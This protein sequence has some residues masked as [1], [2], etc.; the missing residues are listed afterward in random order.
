MRKLIYPAALA[1]DMRALCKA[2]KGRH[3][4]LPA[5]EVREKVMAGGRGAQELT[6]RG[7]RYVSPATPSSLCPIREPRGR[8]IADTVFRVTSWA[9]A[10]GDPLSVKRALAVEAQLVGPLGELK[11][12]NLAVTV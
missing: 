3:L 2:S 6:P 5:L 10:F 12:P 11:S 7:K 9:S 4:A 8:R 1:R